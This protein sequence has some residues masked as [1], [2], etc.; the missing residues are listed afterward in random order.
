MD[1]C[2]L[3]LSWSEPV[4]SASGYSS[5][6]PVSAP[7]WHAHDT[8]TP[9]IL[10]TLCLQNTLG[11]SGTVAHLWPRRARIR[12]DRP[13][14]SSVEVEPLWSFDNVF[15]TVGHRLGGSPG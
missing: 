11:L 1:T 12:W 4:C 2:Q 14:S 15:Y 5:V 13:V 10:V 9:S 3:P 8:G 7:F 6:S